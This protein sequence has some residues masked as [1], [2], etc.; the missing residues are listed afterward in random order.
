LLLEYWK[1][2]DR[3]PVIEEL[4]SL[5]ASGEVDLAVTARIREDITRP[6]LVDRLNELAMLNINEAPS[7]TRIGFWKIG[8][9]VFADDEFADFSSSIADILQKKRARVPDWRDWDH[10]HAHYVLK[11]DVFLTWDKPILS[12][13]DELQNRFAMVVMTPEAY[14]ASRV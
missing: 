12:I 3:F 11:R 6:P 9:D 2:Q 14:L 1:E 5:A 13:A 10:M 8:R 4:L 7:I